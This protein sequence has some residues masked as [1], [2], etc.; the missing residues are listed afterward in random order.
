MYTNFTITYPHFQE[1]G[2][3]KRETHETA[4][5]GAKFDR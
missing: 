4:S 3:R 5:P 1:G 2:E